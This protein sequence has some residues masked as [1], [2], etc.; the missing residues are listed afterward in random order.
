MSIRSNARHR[1]TRRGRA[2]AS[3]ALRPV[4]R[5]IA[6]ALVFTA[7][8]AVGSSLALASPASA[9]S[10]ETWDRLAQCESSGNWSINTGNGYYGGLQVY[11]PTWNGFGGS[12]Y[13]S[14]ADLA[15]RGEQIAVA[16]RVLATQG[17]GAWP[18]CSR[19][20]GLTT[21]DAGTPAPAPAPAP[22]PPTAPAHAHAP[23]PVASGSGSYTVRA[24]DTLSSIARAND[25]TWQA[26]HSANRAVIGSNPNI[27]RVGQ[28]L[29]VGAAPAAAPATAASYTVRA[30]DTLSSIARAHGGGTWQA[31]YEANRDVVGGNPDVIR[32]GQRLAVG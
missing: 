12:Q 21:A 1:Q 15:T 9:A 3:A 19:K 5:R 22:A 17:W 28:S 24:G 8:A 31:L 20:L 27:I 32:V 26:L 30:G 13:A 7:A 29:A 14:R 4:T 11:Q 2:V 16:E 10:G 18:A 6:P 23:A 25:S